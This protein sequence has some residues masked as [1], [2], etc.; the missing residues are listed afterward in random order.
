MDP[1]EA[2]AVLA[3]LEVLAEIQVDPVDLVEARLRLQRLIPEEAVVV[4]SGALFLRRAMLSRPH[5]LPH[6]TLCS[7]C[8]AA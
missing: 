7:V 8:S 6:P 2:Q 3:V 1:V 4:F 5:P